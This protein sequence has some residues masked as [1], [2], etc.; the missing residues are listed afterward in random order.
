MNALAGLV[1]SLSNTTE[2]NFVKR[3]MC[4]G[5]VNHL[6]SPFSNRELHTRLGLNRK[7]LASERRNM[8]EMPCSQVDS[9]ARCS[10]PNAAYRAPRIDKLSDIIVALARVCP[11]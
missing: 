11:L 3:M 4:A 8:L 1:K 7:M 9:S 5:M 2:H 10:M 6:S